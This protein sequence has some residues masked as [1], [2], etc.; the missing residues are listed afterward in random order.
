MTRQRELDHY[1]RACGELAAALR[2]EGD[3]HARER[4]L[5]GV[6]VHLADTLAVHLDHRLR[7]LRWADDRLPAVARPP[8]GL[9]GP[10]LLVAAA[11]AVAPAAQ[12][13]RLG[14]FATPPQVARHLVTATLGPLAGPPER[15]AVC[16]PA[17]G[18]GVFLLAAAR[19]LARRG[20]DL[21]AI[22]DGCLFA[23]DVDPLA[24]DVSAVALALLADGAGPPAAHLRAGD[25]LVDDL[26]PAA[27]FDAVVGNPPFLNQLQLAT[28]RDRALAAALRVRYGDAAAGYADSSGLFLLLALRL[29]RP[30]G[31]VGLILPDSFLAARDA[32]PV[33]RAAADHTIA[34]L[35]RSLDRVFGA[36]VQVC[37]PVLVAAPPPPD[38]VVRRWTGARFTPHPPLRTRADRIRAAPT[39]SWLTAGALGVPSPALR[40][41]R[42]IGDYADATAGFRDQFYGLAPFVY[43]G[44]DGEDPLLVTV[45]LIDPA[46][47]A[48][49]LRETRFAKARYLRP[50]VDLDRLLRDSPLASW[51]RRQLVPKVLLAT[52]TRVL[53]PVVDDAGRWIAS[54]PSITVRPVDG[55]L[56]HV[57]AALA[58]PVLSAWA[59]EHHSGAA[60][61]HDA[62]KLSA[63]QVRALPAPREG[64]AW[65]A[66]AAAFRA[67]SAANGERE[68]REALLRCA[69][70]SCSAYRVADAERD[71]LIAWWA[72]RLPTVSPRPPSPPL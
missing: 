54:T 5:G 28:A 69:E 60:L 1:L 62:V 30:G 63:K 59:H 48:W 31:R 24:G 57:A 55:R 7:L 41:R 13:R 17:A 64:A 49:G 21:R 10:E 56:W 53:E 46:H 50:R 43:E 26:L 25:A 29:A 47:C 68:W 38:L 67:A 6:A 70:A 65:D 11:D 20:G 61:W 36:H 27:S 4:V 40:A 22:V 23:A 39:W 3:E 15:L 16:D 66:A 34:G 44:A 52:Q 58:S 71:E 12:R 45:G 33:R 32:A 42:L 9:A 2:R 18:G 8:P 19:H 51:A 72:P 14:V 37:A 35:W